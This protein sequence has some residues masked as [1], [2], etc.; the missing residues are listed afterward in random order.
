MRGYLQL[1]WIEMLSILS[2]DP[3][4][5][6]G[7]LLLYYCFSPLPLAAMERAWILSPIPILARHTVTHLRRILSGLNVDLSFVLDME[8]FGCR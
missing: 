6:L 3:D 5:L 8:Q 4:P 2:F 7:H 1:E